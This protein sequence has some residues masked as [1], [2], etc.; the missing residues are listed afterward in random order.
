MAL[1]L[2]TRV[3]LPDAVSS[4]SPTLMSSTSLS[5]ESV[6]IGVPAA[7][8][9]QVPPTNDL[10]SEQSV[11][12]DDP[13]IWTSLICTSQL[14]FVHAILSILFDSVSIL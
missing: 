4:A 3:T 6:R 5:P 8:H 14:L 12:I 10:P 11:V 13:S 7:I 1:V 9:T 2:V